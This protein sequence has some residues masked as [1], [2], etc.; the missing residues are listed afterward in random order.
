M[1]QLHII[2]KSMYTW[3]RTWIYTVLQISSN[4]HRI[5][6]N[7][8]CTYIPYTGFTCTYI[9]TY[10]CMYMYIYIPY[11][12]IIHAYIVKTFIVT[13]APGVSPAESCSSS[14]DAGATGRCFFHDVMGTQWLVTTWGG[15]WWSILQGHTGAGS[16]T[17]AGFSGYPWGPRK[18]PDREDI[19]S[20]NLW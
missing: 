4:H 17:I 11:T 15:G 20:G 1:L 7:R 6:H 12:C 5:H 19:P 9:Y 16:G 18:S 2:H 8:S 3:F 13:S 14:S 10:I